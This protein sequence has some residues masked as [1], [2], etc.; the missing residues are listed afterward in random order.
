MRVEASVC[1]FPRDKGFG[2]FGIFNHLGQVGNVSRN[3]RIW[4]R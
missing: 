3:L 4:Q 2:T 1:S